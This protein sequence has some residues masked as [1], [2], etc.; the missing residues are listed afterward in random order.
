[1]WFFSYFSPLLL[2]LLLLLMLLLFKRQLPDWKAP[3]TN[4]FQNHAKQLPNVSSEILEKQPFSTASVAC[5]CCSK[6]ASK[7]SPAGGKTPCLWKTNKFQNRTKKLPNV[8]SET[9]RKGWFFSCGCC[10]K[11][12]SKKSPAGGKTPFRQLLLPAAAAV[13]QLRKNHLPGGFEKIPAGGKTPCLWRTNKFQ[14]RAKKLPNVTSETHRKG[15]WFFSYFSPLLLL[16]LLLLML[17]LFKRQL[18]DWKA[19]WTNKFQNHAKKLPNVSSEILEKQPFSTASVVCGC[20]SKT[21]SKKS[22][23]G[24][25]TPC[26]WRTNKF[27]NRAKKLPNVTSETHRKGWFFSCG[28]CSKTASKKSPAGGKTPCLWRTNKF[29]NRAKQLPNVTSET[30]R[31]GWFFSYFFPLLLLLLLLLLLM[32]LLFKRQLPDWKAPW[33]NKF[34]NHAKKL[35][36]VSSEILEKQPPRQKTA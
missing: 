22:P 8:T 14:N 33:T 31:K 29:Q 1:M 20:C 4:K 13:K 17:L 27:Q 3:W 34:Q 16:L 9:H 7:K 6:T 25:K 35:P 30:H 2:L 5:G 15:M 10:S 11:T 23:A 26:L 36:N 24:G 28:C 19:P 12:A 32:L 21:A 18:P